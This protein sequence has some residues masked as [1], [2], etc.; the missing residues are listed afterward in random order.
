MPK[1]DLHTLIRV[2][3]W[4]VE[5][6]QRALAALLADEEKVL[7]FQR[8]LERELEQE[9]SVASAASADQRF[10]LEP[11]I[12]RCRQ[13]RDNIAAALVLIREKI[14]EARDHLA[15]A[16]RRLKTFEITQEQR[17]AAEEAEENR[18]E[19]IALD[20]MGIDLHRR[21]TA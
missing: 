14:N 16:Y 3:K 2:R 9:K 18:V 4:D 6:R 5:E 20:E 11:Y 1:A 12:Q 21:K 17:E 7:D 8:A 19:Q 13:R 15:E 10:T